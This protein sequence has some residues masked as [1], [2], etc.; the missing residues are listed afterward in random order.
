[1]YVLFLVYTYN[2]SGIDTCGNFAP[3]SRDHWASHSITRP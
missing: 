3:T 1:M 2:I